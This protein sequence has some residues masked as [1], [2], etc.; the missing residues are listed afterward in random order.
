MSVTW[1]L[2][3]RNGIKA[4]TGREWDPETGLYY[5][6]ARYYDP[7]A[8]R[9]ISEDPIGFG[10]GVNFY[11]YVENSPVDLIDPSGL[12]TPRACYGANCYKI[13]C[14]PASPDPCAT[15]PCLRQGP[16][17][18]APPTPFP[19]IGKPACI[20]DLPQQRRCV[21]AGG[22]VP[23]FDRIE[24]RESQP[25]D[26]DQP[27]PQKVTQVPP[28]HGMKG[29]PPRPPSAGAAGFAV[30]IDVINWMNECSDICKR[31]EK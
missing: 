13:V 3:T 1:P 17:N 9:F 29:L 19:T 23:R 12:H 27:F 28:P 11:G 18:T 8:G 4:Y 22:N 7:K 16:R 26:P 5:Y 2:G 24:N 10:G 20:P 30:G 14:A 31:A 6:R 25:D 15:G 21:M